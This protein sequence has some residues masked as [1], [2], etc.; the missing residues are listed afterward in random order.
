MAC[1]PREAIVSGAVITEITAPSEELFHQSLEDMLNDLELQTTAQKH[2][3]RSASS[4]PK[5]D[6]QQS[7]TE[8]CSTSECVCAMSLT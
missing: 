5:S 6:V 8:V 1:R 2:K 4:S 3:P 7:S